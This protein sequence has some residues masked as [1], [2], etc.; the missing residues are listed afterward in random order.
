MADKLVKVWRKN[1]TEIWVLIHVEVQS[2]DEADFAERM[3][4]YH[5]RISDKYRCPVVSL[6]VLGDERRNW[7]PEKFGY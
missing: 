1:G 5:Y 2:Q 6:A 3:F 4:V 7:K